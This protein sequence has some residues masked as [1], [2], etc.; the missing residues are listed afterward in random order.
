[1]MRLFLKYSSGIE[2]E[3]KDDYTLLYNILKRDPIAIIFRY[4]PNHR[5]EPEVYS[6]EKIFLLVK[7]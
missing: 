3:I 6:I 7:A 5:T 4:Y 1:M 2:D